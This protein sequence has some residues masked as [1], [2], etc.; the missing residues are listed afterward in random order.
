M[1][2]E[3]H[4]KRS[5]REFGRAYIFVHRWLDI[6]RGK[7]GFDEKGEEYNYNG[8]LEALHREQRHHKEGI[9]ECV[10]LFGE[11]VRKIA[12]QHI[13]DDFDGKIPNKRDYLGY[14]HSKLIHLVGEGMP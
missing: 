5:L 4:C 1:R 11:D 7:K 14:L 12:E 10:K 13:K 3:E 2:F 6:Y 9:E 8:M